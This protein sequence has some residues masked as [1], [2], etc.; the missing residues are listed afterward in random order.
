MLI[1]AATQL[2]RTIQGVPIILLMAV[3]AIVALFWIFFPLV[4]WGKL[5]V[6]I[7]LLSEI[8]DSADTTARN[9]RPTG[10]PPPKESAVK[11][12]IPGLNG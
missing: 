3:G 7:K 6:I 8:R 9:T 5:N 2:E 11:Y 4:V 10:S 12:R 1:L